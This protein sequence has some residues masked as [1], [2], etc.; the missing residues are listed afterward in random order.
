[1]LVTCLSAQTN[2]RK[3]QLKENGFVWVFALTYNLRVA[4]V[5][6]TQW[7]EHEATGH[8]TSAVRRQK[9]MDALSQFIFS[10]LS[11]QYSM[12]WCHPHVGQVFSPQLI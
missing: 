12:K 4:M 9:V 2:S 7:Q 5:V 1:M 8:V 11:L 10:S 3:K 6:R